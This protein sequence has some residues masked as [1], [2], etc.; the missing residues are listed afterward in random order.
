[1]REEKALKEDGKVF[2]I[3][4]LIVDIAYQDP[5]YN[6]IKSATNAITQHGLLEVFKLEPI[7]GIG[8]SFV[9]RWDG[10]SR[11]VGKKERQDL[12]IDI[13]CVSESE[14]RRFRAEKDGYSGHHSTPLHTAAGWAYEVVI[15]TPKE[16]M[17][18]K[19]NVTFGVLRKLGFPATMSWFQAILSK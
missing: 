12:D 14:G 10:G 7:S 19:A 11:E 5:T 2:A 15:R 4:N 6:I 1:M 3:S 13:E 17:I 18:F 16:G 9:G 8:P